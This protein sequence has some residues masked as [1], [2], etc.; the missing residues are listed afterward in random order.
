LFFLKTTFVPIF[1]KIA[2]RLFISLMLGTFDNFVFLLLTIEAAI[3]GND[4]FFEPL[5]FTPPFI[6]EG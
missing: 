4:A 2:K 3:I 5:I 6:L 1:S